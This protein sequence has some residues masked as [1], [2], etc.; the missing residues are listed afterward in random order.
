MGTCAI[1]VCAILLAAGASRRFGAADKLLAEIDGIPLV[2][3]VAARLCAADLSEVIAVTMP[4]PAGDAVMAVLRQFPVRLAANAEHDRGI[5]TSINRG[6][7]AAPA[8]CGLMIVPGDMPALDANLLARL[9]ADFRRHDGTRIVVPVNAAGEQR[10]PVV[11]PASLRAAL[12]GLQGDAGGKSLLAANSDRIVTAQWTDDQVFEDIDTE[13][14][15][16]AFRGAPAQVA[17]SKP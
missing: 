8:T 9:L 12:L 11:W 4:P 1:D 7:T 3:R 2:A 5:G 13:A 14:E 15:L 16:S 17:R 6:V 10:N